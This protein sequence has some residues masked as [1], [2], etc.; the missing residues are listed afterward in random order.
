MTTGIDYGDEVW[1]VVVGCS[2]K[3]E[4]CRD[5]WAMRMGKR[6]KAMGRP[7]YQNVIGDDSTA[8]AGAV[9]ESSVDV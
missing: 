3:S 2:K 7:E 4:G 5:C 8:R 9:P 6:L 1:N